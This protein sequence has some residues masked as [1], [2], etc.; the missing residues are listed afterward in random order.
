[1]KK[2]G[3]NNTSSN[4]KAVIKILIQINK[5]FRSEVFKRCLEV[6]ILLAALASFV[7]NGA[8][9]V[10][11]VEIPNFHSVTMIG[12]SSKKKLSHEDRSK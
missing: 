7:A 3:V 4:S 11:I 10:S 5:F 9:A 12:N 1:M 8:V 2:K 6:G